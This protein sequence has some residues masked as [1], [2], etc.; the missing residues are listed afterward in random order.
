M[1]TEQLLPTE[2]VPL[3]PLCGGDGP[4]KHSSLRD[5]LF[6]V[7]GEWMLRNCEHCQILWLDPRPSAAAM[8]AL[9][10]TYHTH[11]SADDSKSAL[12]TRLLRASLAAT[13]DYPPD[14]AA[15]S[16]LLGRLVAEI[17]ELE[18]RTRA[19][20]MN[21]AYSDSN[22]RLLDVGCG[23]G[24]FMAKMESLGWKCEGVEPDHK[25]AANARERF[26]VPVHEGTLDTVHLPAETFDAVTMSHVIEHVPNSK[27]L[28]GQILELLRP[29][30]TLSVITPNA[31]ALGHE[32]FGR[33]WRGL[34]P[35]RHFVV[36]SPSA[37]KRLALE[38]GFGAAEALTLARSAKGMY[39]FSNDLKRIESGHTGRLP[40]LQSSLFYLRE[41]ALKRR[42]PVGEEILMFATKA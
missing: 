5:A 22:P 32:H 25:A 21:L 6:G 1:K 14:G 10:S 2:R 16:T 34:E 8:T 12:K 4:V 26:G 31:L 37:L 30:G 42:K 36:Y 20:V 39:R 40:R 38:T 18:E 15:A 19:S 7:P 17:P 11:E 41:L 33:S 24:L 23:N 9:Y 28:F 29:G 35:P 27:E 13:L 3:C